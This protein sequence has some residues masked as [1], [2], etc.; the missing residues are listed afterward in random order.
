MNLVQLDNSYNIK[1]IVVNLPDDYVGTMIAQQYINKKNL[2]ILS[3]SYL[4]GFVSA[5]KSLYQLVDNPAYTET[6]YLLNNCDAFDLGNQV[7]FSEY[8]C[9]TYG[10]PKIRDDFNINFNS[11]L[12]YFINWSG[13]S[14]IEPWGRWID[15]GSLTID[16][17]NL[18]PLS[19]YN[20]KLNLGAVP[21]V[22]EC[23]QLD[24]A[25]AGNPSF[26]KCIGVRD[27]VELVISSNKLGQASFKV[28]D[29]GQ[30]IKRSGEDQRDMRFSLISMK[31]FKK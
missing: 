5:N 19:H 15:G 30:R 25:A 14:V 27:T 13:F 4:T 29:L 7:R 17:D 22:S 24:F 9:G 8:Y 23:R 16:F 3:P 2:Y 10:K 6:F 26:R 1:N 21:D 31:V 18:E 11:P 28:M 12:P 20:I